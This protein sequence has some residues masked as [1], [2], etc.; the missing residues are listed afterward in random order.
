MLLKLILGADPQALSRDEDNAVILATFASCNLKSSSGEIIEILA[1][2]GDCHSSYWSIWP[3]HTTYHIVLL[4]GV[5]MNH[6]NKKGY[7]ALSIAAAN[8]N[9][10]LVTTLMHYGQSHIY[11]VQVT[12]GQHTQVGTP[13]YPIILEH[14]LFI[15]LAV[16]VSTVAT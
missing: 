4:A 10:P 1:H 6:V 15:L 14:C 8:G 13:Q 9:L 11:S 2:T 7:S 3:F 16:L 12:I 5:N